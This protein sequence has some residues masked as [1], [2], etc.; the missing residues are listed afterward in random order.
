MAKPLG[1]RLHDIK[2]ELERVEKE[3]GE[4][5]MAPGDLQDFKLVVDHVRLSVWALISA[6]W[7]DEYKDLGAPQTKQIIARFR[8]QRG[9]DIC[10]AVVKDI[11]GGVIP[12]SSSDLE[13]FHSTLQATVEQTGRALGRGDN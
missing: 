10:R 1:Q 2:V 13:R 11:E 4:G 6:G 5:T 9:E 7:S 12:A 3:L 8:L